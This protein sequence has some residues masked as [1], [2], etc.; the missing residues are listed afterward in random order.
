MRLL[1]P[2]L[3]LLVYLLALAM[4]LE[5]SANPRLGTRPREGLFGGYPGAGRPIS[6]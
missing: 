3:Y 1:A 5:F 6:S 4:L 2:P